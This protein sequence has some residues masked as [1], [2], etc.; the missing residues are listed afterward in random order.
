MTDVLI[1][2]SARP[3]L[4][5]LADAVAKLRAQGARVYLAATFHLKPVAEEISEAGFAD[6]HQLPRSVSHRSSTLRRQAR[7]APKSMRVWLQAKGDA[8]LRTHARKADVFVALDSNAVYSVWRLAQHNRAAEAVF[9][10]GPALKTVSDLTEDGAE[11]RRGVLTTLPSPSVLARDMRRSV[12]GLPAVVMRTAT[13]R[14]VM[15]SAVGARFWRGAVSA[16][17][18]PTGVRASASRYVAEGMQWAGRTSGAAI[19]LAAAASKIADLGLKAALLN[20]SVMEEISRGLDPRNLSQAVAAQLDHADAQFAKGEFGEASKALNTALM[21]DFHRVVHI[22]Q[23]SSPLAERA[24]AYVEPLYASRTM[25]V[26]GAP[27]G[28]ERPY[29][30]VPEDRPLR[31]LV[32]TSANA[33]FL[34]HVLSHFGDHPAVE[35][36]FLDLAEHKSLKRISWSA[37]RML[38]DRLAGDA[39][40]YQ[41]EVERLMR[42]HLDWA[43]TVFLDWSVGPAA[44]L[45]TVDPGDTRIVVRLHS[46]EAFTRWPHMTDFSRVD[47]LVFVA[48]HVRDL[49]TS[50]VPQLRGEH[51][52]RTHILDNAMDLSGFARPKPPEARFTLGLI[53]IGQVAKDPLWAV[54]VLERLRARDERYRLLLMGG[55]MNPKTSRAT[56][57]YLSRFEKVLRPLESSGA[58]VRLGPTDDVPSALTD[59]GTI[60]SSSVREGSHVGLM[61]GAAS[62]A[63][64]V[65]R[66]WPFY[67]GRR[68]SARTLYPEG[69]VVGSP[70]EAAKRI[71][72]TTASEETWLKAGRLASQHALSVWDW[73]VVRE[74]FEELLLEEK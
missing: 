68:N 51:A 22:D 69:W 64:P 41:E 46:Y 58:V 40:D 56:S 74:Q 29:A 7:E 13:A 1:I 6:T 54:E 24:E 27:R 53:G 11:G 14:P 12:N 45:T 61:E 9:G 37:R 21:L 49:V 65:V 72:E 57:E 5:V 25:R 36:R 60:I 44:M 38:E 18:V 43:D 30:P 67:A 23:L 28:R 4:A 48:P 47:D 3:Q 63:V 19:A 71:L 20:E 10:L 33:N 66:D 62:A 55:D 17:G 35:L 16:P 73:P 59:I 42:P 70:E 15:R 2:A 39:S 50:V 26:L 31:L 32:T 8:W 52:P 34:H